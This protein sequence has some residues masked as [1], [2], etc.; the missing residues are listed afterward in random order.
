[1]FLPFCSCLLGYTGTLLCIIIK[2]DFCKFPSSS[3]FLPCLSTMS[4]QTYTRRFALPVSLH[5]K[6][7][8]ME[9]RITI[10]RLST[11]GA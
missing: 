11:A 4:L 6:L 5:V 7:A 9:W 1:M 8:G 2:A 10:T 3:S